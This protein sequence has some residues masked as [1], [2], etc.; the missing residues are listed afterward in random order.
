[1]RIISGRF[2]GR[3]LK[4]P[5]DWEI[6][7]TGDRL[8]ET[9]FNILGPDISGAVLLDVFGGTGAIGIEALSRGA[10]EVIFIEN[11]SA[12]HRLILQ[13]LQLC[14][15]ENG[16]RIL[17]QDAFM[18]LRLLARQGFRADIAYFDPPYDW[19]PYNDLLEIAFARQLL[20]PNGRAVIEHHR[21]ARLPEAGK[22]YRRSRVVR[23]G[24]HCISFYECQQEVRSQESEVRVESE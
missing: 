17:K 6:R 2:R 20:T 11:S 1:M 24:D 14:K 21:K 9:L 19:E 3:K 5:E 7:P 8:K 16:Y 12:A 4:G 18:A 13:N 23:Q 10:R 15:I 22:T